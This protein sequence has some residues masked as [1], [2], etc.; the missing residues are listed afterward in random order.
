MGEGGGGEGVTINVGYMMMVIHYLYINEDQ[1]DYNRQIDNK[2]R[3]E[4]WGGG[5]ELGETHIKNTTRF[6]QFCRSTF[7]GNFKECI[8]NQDVDLL[9]PSK[10]SILRR[11]LL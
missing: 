1:C 6:N 9:I 8:Q 4:F 3:G 7:R 5:E 2:K 10:R 11:H